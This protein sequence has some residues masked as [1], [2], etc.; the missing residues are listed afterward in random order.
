MRSV[1]WLVLGGTA[2][3]VATALVLL[4]P[5]WIAGA[6]AGVASWRGWLGAARAAAIVA[7]WVW[8]DALVASIPGL[9]PVGAAHLR[10]RR[11]FWIG[12]LVAIELVV[13][14]NVAGS[15]WELAR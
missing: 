4:P 5:G 12:A 9:A 11:A 8:W 6:E 15:L 2:A 14:R 3:V 13:A 1:T 7:A 10:G